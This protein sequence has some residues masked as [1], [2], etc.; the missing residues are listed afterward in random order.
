MPF[1]LRK[2]GPMPMK[3]ACSLST[4]ALRTLRNNKPT[5]SI[6]YSPHEPLPSPCPR[7]PLLAHRCVAIVH[8]CRPRA[9]RC[10][11]RAVRCLAA[12]RRLRSL[13]PSAVREPSSKRTNDVDGGEDLSYQGAEAR[14]AAE[15]GE[16]LLMWAKD[17][18]VAK[19][20]AELVKLNNLVTKIV[21]TAAS[22][23]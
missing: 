9:H 15:V 5:S 23:H 14:M 11:P 4:L 22:Q 6:R 3:M 19:I 13:P 2:P 12:C 17:D 18:A 10:R 20:L 16:C 7:H 1:P 21:S 8:R